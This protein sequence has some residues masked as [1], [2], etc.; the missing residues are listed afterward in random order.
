[1]LLLYYLETGGRATPACPPAPPGPDT[2]DVR[3]QAPCRRCQLAGT[4]CVFEKPEKKNAQVMGNASVEYVA[5]WLLFVV[6]KLIV[7]I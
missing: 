3:L 4:P 5:P 7:A 2:A 6:M 1:M